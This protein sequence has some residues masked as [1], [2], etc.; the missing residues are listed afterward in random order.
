MIELLR[1][2]HA[3]GLQSGLA[4]KPE[5]DRILTRQLR[6]L[7]CWLPRTL[8]AADPGNPSGLKTLAIGFSS[9][10]NPPLARS[11]I[12]RL[13]DESRIVAALCFRPRWLASLAIGLIRTAACLSAG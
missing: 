12:A 13:P 7:P 8:P 2:R 6:A 5:S 1:A 3:E 11:G 9:A 10:Q 4:W